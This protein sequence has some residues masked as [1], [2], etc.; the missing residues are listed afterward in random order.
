MA[1]LERSLFQRCRALRK[2]TTTSSVSSKATTSTSNTENLLPSSCPP[3]LFL[4]LPRPRAHRRVRLRAVPEKHPPARTLSPAHP[5]RPAGLGLHSR[6]PPSPPPQIPIHRPLRPDPGNHLTTEHGVW[7][8]ASLRSLEQ[9]LSSL[10]WHR[11]FRSCVLG[12]HG[13]RLIGTEGWMCH[14]N[15]KRSNGTII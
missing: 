4:P 14:L 11:L 2:E 10:S 9:R 8:R 13:R 15:L 6:T 1:Q 7:L 5:H 3:P 12:F